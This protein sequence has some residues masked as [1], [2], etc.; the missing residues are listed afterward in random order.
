MDAL[1]W[2]AKKEVEFFGEDSLQLDKIVALTIAWGRKH[3]IDNPDKQLLHCYEEVA[4]IGRLTLRGNYD[5]EELMKE[6]GDVLITVTILSDIFG[7]NIF[8]C[9][10]KSLHK[11]ERRTGKTVDGNFIKDSQSDIKEKDA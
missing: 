5:K 8:E 11:I 1:I 7:Y 6:I 9:W 3:K 4:E 2:R 10:E